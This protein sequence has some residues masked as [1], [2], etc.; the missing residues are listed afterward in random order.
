VAEDAAVLLQCRVIAVCAQLRQ[1]GG[2]VLDVA[3][4]EG[5]GAGGFGGHGISRHLVLKL[6][7]D[8]VSELSTRPTHGRR[9]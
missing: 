8:S 5:D 4:K 3:E 9:V 6:V 2:R 1:S 7:V